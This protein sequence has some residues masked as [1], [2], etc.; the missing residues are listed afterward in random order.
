MSVQES[1]TGLAAHDAIGRY[2]QDEINGFTDELLDRFVELIAPEG[3]SSVLDAMAGDGNLTARIHAWCE[4]KGVRFPETTLM[5]FSRVQCEFARARLADVPARVVWGDVLTMSPRDGGAALAD[6]TF[7]RVAIK[8]GNHEI[9]RERQAALYEAAYRVTRPGGLFVNLGFVFD[10]EEERREFTEIT[11][12]KDAIVGMKDAVVNRYFLTRTE[13]H[14]LLARAGFVDIRSAQ[15]FTYTI[16]SEVVEREYF[17]RDGMEA[18]NLDLQASQA[19][20]MA[21]RRRRRILFEDDR[22][23]MIAPG[24]ITVARRPTWE[25]SNRAVF[26]Q[27]PYEFLRHLECHRELLGKTVQA[28]PK[29]SSVLDLG[30]GPGLLADRFVDRVSR[31]RGLEISPEFLARCT[32]RHAANSAFTF[33]QGDVGAADYGS[34]WD[35]VTIL[36]LLNLPGIDPVQV[37]KKAHAALRD[38]GRLV[39]SGPTSRESYR[40][41][42]PFMREQLAKE[43]LLETCE[44]LFRAVGEANDRLCP[45]QGN[46]WSIEGMIALLKELGFRA[47]PDGDTSIYY[48]FGFMVVAEK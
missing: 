28:V 2:R 11:R 29:G 16:R 35:A 41:A 6:G 30:C 45:G 14:D 40:K 46:Y 31:Y 1:A 15:E 12:V 21:L 48:G 24:E 26:R 9:P 22:S 33:E 44:P 17:S 13:L 42:E 34:G 43:G 32:E 10:D 3:A 23:V 25:E 37:L 8:S 19:R 39:V 20:A 36:N 7:D 4:R 38:G 18:A 47:V 27:C 5:E